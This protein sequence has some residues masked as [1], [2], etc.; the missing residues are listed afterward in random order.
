[1]TDHLPVNM[2][3]QPDAWTCGPTCLHAVYRYYGY[4]VDLQSLIA[5]VP[6]LEGGGTLAV[7]LGCDALDHGFRARMYTFNLTVF[8]PTWFGER[9]VD[10]AG[11]LREQ[12]EYKREHARLQVATPAYLEFLKR[13][14]ECR[15]SDL[16]P[17]LIRKYLSRN[18]PI[19][20]GLSSTYLYSESREI[21]P[22]QEPSDV[23][24][25]PQGHFVVLRGYDPLTKRVRVAD[26]YH[27]NPWSQNLDYEVSIERAITAI[28][29]G[30]LTFDANL[31]VIR[32]ATDAH[33]VVP[34]PS[35][36]D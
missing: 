14:G 8:D 20:T 5:R 11:K 13:G 26:P 35:T 18:V 15:M 12:A 3:R 29:L 32:P 10:I 28:L 36:E 6:K 4:Q 27:K 16:S 1:M 24:G 7:L 2:L 33:S 19:L 30:V 17:K 34:Q 25:E 31:L 23:R 9:V 22:T 21:N